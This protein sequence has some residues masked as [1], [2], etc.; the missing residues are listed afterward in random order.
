M[1]FIWFIRTLAISRVCSSTHHFH[2]YSLLILFQLLL[3]L[4]S[5]NYGFCKDRSVSRAVKEGFFISLSFVDLCI[6]PCRRRWQRRE[7]GQML[8]SRTFFESLRSFWKMEWRS[9]ASSSSIAFMEGFTCSFFL[10][11][12]ILGDIISLSYQGR[13]NET[14]VQIIN[15]ISMLV[16]NNRDDQSL[17]RI[18]VLSVIPSFSPFE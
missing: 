13:S 10:E 9:T 5:T 14:M 18:I 17:C 3:W 11:E 15:T 1:N 2:V 4:N 7:N 8:R 16:Q 12:K 6:L